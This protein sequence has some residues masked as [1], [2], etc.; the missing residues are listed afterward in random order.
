VENELG[1]SA[2]GGGGRGSVEEEGN[3][4]RGDLSGTGGRLEARVSTMSKRPSFSQIKSSD[5]FII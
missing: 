3:V 1:W 5:G 2:E 4:E